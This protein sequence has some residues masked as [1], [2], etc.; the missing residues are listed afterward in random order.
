[1]E[2]ETRTV[3]GS[4][5]T[6][7]FQ[8]LTARQAV[9]IMNDWVGVLGANAEKVLAVVGKWLTDEE[10]TVDDINAERIFQ[11]MVA[12]DSL[13]I[14]AFKTLSWVLTTPRLFDLAK[15]V[16][17]GATID[18]VPCDDEGMCPTFRKRPHEIYFALMW[19][20]MANY[21]DY[22]PFLGGDI[23]ASDSPPKNDPTDNGSIQN[24]PA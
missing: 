9:G 15:I 20:I 4:N 16:L 22:F 17:A 7:V 24:Q 21:E 2:K 5:H 19:A 1:M 11:A 18:G 23:E 13:V 8:I 12:G 3:V 14:D 6:Y 10:S